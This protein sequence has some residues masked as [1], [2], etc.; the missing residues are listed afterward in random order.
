[1][2]EIGSFNLRFISYL[3]TVIYSSKNDI[4]SIFIFKHRQLGT[5]SDLIK[6]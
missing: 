1:M 2:K 3:N 4:P 6:L 5:L